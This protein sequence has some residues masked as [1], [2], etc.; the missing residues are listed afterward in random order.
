MRPKEGTYLAHGQGNPLLGL[1]PREHAHF[2]LR[3]EHR[4]LHGDRVWMRRDVVWQDQYGRLATAH[5]ITR[6]GEDEVGVGAEHLGHE[7]L[8]HRHRDLGPTLDQ[9]RTPA[10]YTA[11]VHD[12]GHLRP[13]PNGL[14]RHG[15]DDAI[16]RPF[17]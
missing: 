4:A 6:H 5:E 14:R 12:V 13:E 16:R 10:G 3:R 2:A 11:V 8:D 1:L 9:F 7:F 15:R 17:Q